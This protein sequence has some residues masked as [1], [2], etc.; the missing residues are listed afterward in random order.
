MDFFYSERILNRY[1]STKIL[2][3]LLK[4]LDNDYHI[5]DTHVYF[6]FPVHLNDEAKLLEMDLFLISAK[7]GI[8][9]FKCL[10][11]SERTLNTDII[12]ESTDELEDIY[13][14]IYSKLVKS[15]TL[16]K[17][18]RELKF[19]IKPV[20]F[21][22]NDDYKKLNIDF[23]W[24]EVSIVSDL[25]SLRL[26]IRDNSETIDNDSFT[27]IIS[28]LEGSKCL[29]KKKEGISSTTPLTKGQ[30]IEQIEASIS[31][32]DNEQ[33]R[34]GFR[35]IDGPQR[36]RGLAGSGKTIILAMKAAQIHLTEPNAEIV[37]TYYTKNLRG[38][39]KN[40]I[41]L[42][43]R[44][45]SLFDPNWD[46]IHIMHAWG[47]R[48]LDGVYYNTCIKN[49]YVPKSFTDANRL[50]RD[51]FNEVCKLIAEE[52]LDEMYDY[53]LIDEAQ[54]FPI[55]FYR[56]C[57]KIVRNN[58][59]IWAYDECQ[60]ILNTSLQNPIKTFGKKAD[61]T[62]YIDFSHDAE[63]DQDLVLHKCYR[64]PRKVL[65]SA[66]ALGMGIYSNIVQ[67]P[68]SKELWID[69]GF[70][71]VSGEYNKGDVMK[72][73]R[74]ERNSPLLK[75]TLIDASQNPMKWDY[76]ESFEE[77]CT[78]VVKQILDD[79]K[80]GLKPEDIM[81]ISL[82]DRHARA[83]F[84]TISSLLY[85]QSV[86]TFN[87]LQLPTYNTQFFNEGEITLSTVY[88]AKGNEAAHVF[89]VGIDAIFKN[90]DSR[91]ARNKIFTSITRAKAWVDITGIGAPA[92][93]FYNEMNKIV[94]N[95][96]E[97][98]FIMPDLSKLETFQRDLEHEQ[99]K[100]NDIF[101]KLEESSQELGIDKEELLKVLLEKEQTDSKVKK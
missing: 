78:Y 43:Y 34:A 90:K 85:D 88:R 16:R 46:K 12:T 3:E 71:V 37:F 66:F 24:D 83:Y 1:P 10:G 6:N 93:E 17:N 5:D 8:F 25:D 77:E 35:I 21:F 11:N 4:E 40:L 76:F 42:F 63:K 72:I 60:N 101:R 74:P 54:D 39:V 84:N 100:L 61:G 27:E 48:N 18:V 80:E 36:I 67:L 96:F 20:L 14:N 44:Q 59:V 28:I 75:N 31:T 15:R 26:I 19:S 82:D 45:F 33:K 55:H 7:Y 94:N 62:P 64:N 70:D 57:R 49:G 29:T 92:K 81:V 47:G 87:L 53:I 89:I 51:P 58:R 41:T 50:Y 91:I 68:E 97:L 65:V 13:S 98:N 56:L 95:N 86:S 23:E 2:I 79:L 9:I 22:S 38:Y 99:A 73:V 32:F 69:W 30:I 52:N